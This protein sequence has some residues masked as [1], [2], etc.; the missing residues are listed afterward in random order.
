MKKEWTEERETREKIWVEGK[1][2]M[3]ERWTEGRKTGKKERN[4]IF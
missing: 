3:M 2:G 4:K 1:S